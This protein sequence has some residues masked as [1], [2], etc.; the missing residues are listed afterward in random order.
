MRYTVEYYDDEDCR[1]FWA[2]VE[3][4]G[5]RG[6][7]LERCTT[8]AE[9]ESFARAYTAIERKCG[10]VGCSFCDPY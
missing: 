5:G 6:T 10:E 1:P 4:R 7:T 8:E 2:V 3:W 9:A